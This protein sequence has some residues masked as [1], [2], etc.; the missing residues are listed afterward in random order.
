MPLFARFAIPVDTATSY[1]G[2][3]LEIEIVRDVKQ[4]GQIIIPKHSHLFGRIVGLLREFYP[5]REVTL[6]IQFHHV[7]ING[8]QVPVSIAALVLGT[9]E[10]PQS[11]PSQGSGHI[12]RITLYG[13]TDLHFNNTPC[14]GGKPRSL[15]M[16]FHL[17]G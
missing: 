7:E 2:D 17:R 6:S 9:V 16:S 13:T 1:A 5:Q 11:L 8:K 4:D 15:L 3:P 12:A 10:H 14:N